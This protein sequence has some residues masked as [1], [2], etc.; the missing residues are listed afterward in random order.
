M[1]ACQPQFDK[2]QPYRKWYEMLK[3][4]MAER[5]QILLRLWCYRLFFNTVKRQNTIWLFT[6]N[7]P[8]QPH[9]KQLLWNTWGQWVFFTIRCGFGN[10]NTQI[11]SKQL[12]WHNSTGNISRGTS[13]LHL[14]IAYY[15]RVD[16]GP[17]QTATP[18]NWEL[19][20]TDRELHKVVY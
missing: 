5:D 11:S 19:Q 12:L 10:V 14:K 8:V 2:T 3:C 13:M 20:R 18:I 7:Q 15:R 1:L 16:Y 17:W 4:D 9:I 6:G